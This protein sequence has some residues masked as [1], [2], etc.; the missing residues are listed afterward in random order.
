MK[1][2]AF[3]PSSDLLQEVGGVESGLRRARRLGRVGRIGIVL[4]IASFGA[5]L[6]D[7][8]PIDLLGLP[9]YVLVPLLVTFLACVVAAAFAWFI[10]E[11]R[12]PFRYTCYVANFTAAASEKDGEPCTPIEPMMSWL[13]PDITRLLNERLPERILYL[14][15]DSQKEGARA[16]LSD[17]IHVSGTYLIRSR[18][19]SG[20]SEPRLSTEQGEAPDPQTSEPQVDSPE[21]EAQEEWEL[22]ILPRIRVG[23]PSRAE[24]LAKDVR[25]SLRDKGRYRLEEEE[26]ER[27]LEQVYH[28]VATEVYDQIGED[29]DRKVKLL[30]TSYLRAVALYHEARDLERSNTLNAY[31]AAGKLY[32]RAANLLDPY[33]AFLVKPPASWFL[34]FD[35]R[36]RG[37]L[38]KVADFVRKLHYWPRRGLQR[39]EALLARVEMGCAKMRLFRHQLS[40]LLAQRRVSPYEAK[41]FAERAL[42]R[43]E[44]LSADAKERS[45][46][47]DLLFDAN[48]TMALT[49]VL[50]HDAGE[51]RKHLRRA[52]ETR[53]RST[54]EN[55]VYLL[56]DALV[57]ESISARL[58]TL[59][60]AAELHPRFE[61]IAFARAYRQEMAWRS[62]RHPTRDKLAAEAV[63]KAYEAVLLVNPGNI[64]ALA[65]CGY[66]NWLI[67]KNCRAREC[68]E[69]A[70]D[71]AEFIE[72]TVVSEI[73][74]GLARIDVEKG[75]FD[76]A[77]RHVTRGDAEARAYGPTHYVS[78]TERQYLFELIGEDIWG[79]FAVL[80]E[81]VVSDS[82][83]LM[84]PI[85]SEQE[86]SAGP[87]RVEYTASRC[88]D[89]VPDEVVSFVLTEYGEA[90]GRLYLRSG[91]PGYKE[92][93]RL[94]FEKSCGLTPRDA[95]CWRNLAR[96]SDMPERLAL[97]YKA[98][99]LEPRRPE[100]CRELIEVCAEEVES[101]AATALGEQQKASE[102]WQE[103]KGIDHQIVCKRKEY[104]SEVARSVVAE[105]R[106]SEGRDVLLRS[107]GP[108][109]RVVD[110]ANDIGKLQRQV[111]AL[112]GAIANH[113]GKAA[114]AARWMEALER[115]ADSLAERS[116]PH[117]W[118]WTSSVAE[119]RRP[120]R[121]AVGKAAGEGE[122][123]GSAVGEAPHERAPETAAFGGTRDP[124]NWDC[125]TDTR[126]CE[127]A[128]WERELNM[129]HV[130][131]L[132]AWA[133]L[134]LTECRYSTAADLEKYKEL[135]HVIEQRHSPGDFFILLVLY[136]LDRD[137]ERAERLTSIV[138]CWLRDD[139]ADHDS[140]S[141]MDR[142]FARRAGLDTQRQIEYLEAAVEA[143]GSR[144]V[145]AKLALAHARRG[146]ELFEMG[147][148]RHKQ[149]EFKEAASHYAEAASTAE[150]LSISSHPDRGPQ[151]PFGEANAY[152]WGLALIRQG[153]CHLREGLVASGQKA[154]RHGLSWY[155]PRRPL[156]EAMRGLEDTGQRAL[157]RLSYEHLLRTGGFPEE[158]NRTMV[159][160]C[161]ESLPRP[162]EP[163]PE[164]APETRVNVLTP[165]AVEIDESL[166][167]AIAET[168]DLGD[169]L[170]AGLAAR[171]RGSIEEGY[172]VKIPGIR[173]RLA[174]FSKPGSFRL[175]LNEVVDYSGILGCV[176]SASPTREE[177]EGA[178]SGARQEIEAAMVRRLVLWVEVQEVLNL[179]HQHCSEQYMADIPGSETH[180]HILP[181]TALVQ[182]LVRER[183]PINEFQRI[184]GLYRQQRDRA[185]VDEMVAAVRMIRAIRPRLWGNDASY[186]RH[187]V[188]PQ[189]Q[190]WLAAKVRSASGVEVLVLTGEERS[191][192]LGEIRGRLAEEGDAAIVVSDAALR[193]HVWRLISGDLPD[194][195]VLAEAELVEDLS[196]DEPLI[197]FVSRSGELKG[198]RS[199]PSGE[200]P[201]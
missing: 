93:A 149:E 57:A 20:P 166:G 102:K 92:S 64:G 129:L 22:V 178:F 181:L 60:M 167:S 186:N 152:T 184:Y 67:G 173:F 87:G 49:L 19:T 25:H 108:P 187:V 73:C 33:D 61:V 5:Q 148:S 34:R 23:P 85:L 201:S 196:G 98:L 190:R 11:S 110:L 63:T 138:K 194:T 80:M 84:K 118:L 158:I 109:T 91:A 106:I 29:V 75:R 176:G 170:V 126:L 189:T 150:R 70:L 161:T 74:Y 105:D 79:R 66:V 71:Y 94:A 69:R 163:Q 117:H 171:L 81:G 146:N 177:V 136:S 185:T 174:P 145:R 50:L 120:E 103:A 47:L 89:T 107:V 164:G 135:L 21:S 168:M 7:A 17:H 172:G 151:E 59:N 112:P 99:A 42:R 195:P 39:R 97:L 156:H 15:P 16:D 130:R 95:S 128:V 124:F 53:P 123:K 165:I 88:S 180:D 65:N 200:A 147:A 38:R 143:Q 45:D 78:L 14:D 56:A 86:E 82:E 197:E 40:L 62:G 101:G 37:G 115:S 13:A 55:A 27:L 140:L 141:L 116:L 18:A 121:S 111:A 127:E 137:Q 24:T 26:Y 155:G 54:T 31:K 90:C 36:L 52:G 179:L 9:W 58:D 104:E 160:W 1:L 6:V 183:V 169:L 119:A 114:A 12:R 199:A 182:E 159:E 3:L 77:Y 142:E 32:R 96:V 198:T 2:A 83:D 162:P 144:W 125:L 35:Y 76:S 51:A 8:V 134:R 193:K 191:R 28:Q 43:A 30:P 48:A 100:L 131:T 139:A 157:L 175:L 153:V 4:G 72:E 188:G 132:R 46:L 10:E 41:R 192:V 154:I 113:A 44:G 122:P 133:W 68:F